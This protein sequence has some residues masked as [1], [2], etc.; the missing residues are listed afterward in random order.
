MRGLSELELRGLTNMVEDPDYDAC[1]NDDDPLIPAWNSCV[2]RGLAAYWIDGEA[3]ERWDINDLGRLAL[4]VHHAV[5][6]R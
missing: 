6:S 5:T 1:G 4:R 3:A 2:D